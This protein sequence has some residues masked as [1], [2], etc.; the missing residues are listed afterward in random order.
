MLDWF[1]K[2]SNVVKF[3]LLILPLVGWI[4]EL[5]IRWSQVIKEASVLNIVV[6]IVY[7]VFGWAWVL[8]VIDAV[9]VLLGKNMLFM[10]E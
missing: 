5:V 1:N 6:A 8:T 9:F 10:G 4:F 7:T 2:Q 3:I